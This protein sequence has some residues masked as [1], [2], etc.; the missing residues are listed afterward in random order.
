VRP[1]GYDVVWRD[2]RGRERILECHWNTPVH[3]DGVVYGSSGRHSGEAELRAVELETGKVLWS[4][5]GLLHASLLSVDGHFVAL[6]EDGVLRLLRHNRTKYDPVA[7][8][9]LR[10]DG[11]RL[12]DPPAW[13]P[14]VLAHGIL[15]VRG[16][17]QLVALEL[18]P[19]S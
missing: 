4:E 17:S 18:I 1:G 11:R 9:T 14:P 3:E 7:E 19:D 12:I 15:Y 16:K 10:H 5:P 2:G 8:L 6:S 13:N